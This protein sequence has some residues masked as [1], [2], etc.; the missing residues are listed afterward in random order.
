MRVTGAQLTLV[1]TIV[2]IC[3][4]FPQI[5]KGPV[6]F[7]TIPAFIESLPPIAFH[8]LAGVFLAKCSRGFIAGAGRQQELNS[9]FAPNIHHDL[10]GL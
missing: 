7:D 1:G 8:C 10:Q 4:Y 9:L 5:P 3:A 6:R 2:N